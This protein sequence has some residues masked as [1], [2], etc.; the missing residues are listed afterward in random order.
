MQGSDKQNE[1]GTRQMPWTPMEH[2]LSSGFGADDF[3]SN[4]YTRSSQ[5]QWQNLSAEL[6]DQRGKAVYKH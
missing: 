5:Q 4:T 6:L 3:G 2:G 1:G